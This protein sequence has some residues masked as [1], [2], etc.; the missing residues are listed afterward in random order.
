MFGRKHQKVKA[1]IPLY[2]D[3]GLSP[4]ERR[5]VEEHLKICDECRAEW[6]SIR[7]TVSLLR[8]VPRVP[9]PRSFAVRA[10]DLEKA[11]VPLGLNLARAFTALAAAAL[12]LL[13]G[14]DLITVRAAAP[15]G[16][17]PA[18]MVVE[19]PSPEPERIKA[20]PTAPLTTKNVEVTAQQAEEHPPETPTPVPAP[21]PAPLPERTSR[22]RLR[23]LPWEIA[24]GAGAVAGGIISLILGRRR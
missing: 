8:E 6:E 22:L 14:L 2:G 7:W 21:T 13:L 24:A 17:A 18:P 15:R 23:W 11:R 12:I 1:L 9:A 4:E 5:M 3:E 10:A 20:A 16:M 19:M